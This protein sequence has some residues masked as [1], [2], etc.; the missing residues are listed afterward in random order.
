MGII[1]SI[2]SPSSNL[3]RSVS[4]N[5]SQSG[6][7]KHS[8]FQHNISSIPFLPASIISLTTSAHASITGFN[9]V[10]ECSAA[11]NNANTFNGVVLFPAPFNRLSRLLRQTHKLTGTPPFPKQPDKSPSRTPI[12]MSILYVF[13]YGEFQHSWRASSKLP[14][15]ASSSVPFASREPFILRTREMRGIDHA[16]SPG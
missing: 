15:S 9:L 13:G 8:D 2:L 11:N 1:H 7:A 14:V 16:S 5:S 4:I 3:T 10:I 12:Q 6:F